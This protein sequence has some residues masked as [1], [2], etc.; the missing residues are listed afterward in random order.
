MAITHKKLLYL[1]IACSTWVGVN[2][3]FAQNNQG[4]SEVPLPQQGPPQQGGG[5]HHEPLS[6]EERKKIEASKTAFITS[7]L[8]LSTE[9]AKDF[10]PVH[11]EYQERKKASRAAMKKIMIAIEKESKTDEEAR[12]NLKEILKLRETDLALDG[13]YQER[14][15]RILKP[16]QLACLYA[17]EREFARMMMQQLQKGKGGSTPPPR[18]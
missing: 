4:L 11:A 2:S 5:H 15:L 7:K 13:E 12:E 1:F 16:T 3:A 18:P 17:T 9:Q 10:W 8:K 6:D 14:F